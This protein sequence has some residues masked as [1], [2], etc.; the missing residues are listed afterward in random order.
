MKV[1]LNEKVYYINLDL[2][3]YVEIAKDSK[4]L[5]KIYFSSTEVLEIDASEVLP[6]IQALNWQSTK[7]VAATDPAKEKPKFPVTK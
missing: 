5:A 7:S 3:K 1:F 6:V 2:V 4:G